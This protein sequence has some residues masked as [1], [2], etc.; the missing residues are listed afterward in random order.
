MGLTRSV[1]G[2]NGM[3]R[4]TGT[5]RRVFEHSLGTPYL[6]TRKLAE[7]EYRRQPQIAELNALNAALAVI[8]FK[9]QFE[10]YDLIEPSDAVIFETCTF[11]IDRVE[12]PS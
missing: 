11:E 9:Q 6:P 7:D 12:F 10:L 8:R 3:V 1:V 4:I 2:L 5:D